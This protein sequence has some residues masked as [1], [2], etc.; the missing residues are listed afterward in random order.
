MTQRVVPFQGDSS[1]DR[2]AFL[3]SGSQGGWLGK[4][5]FFPYVVIRFRLSRPECPLALPVV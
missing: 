5:N 1:V 3:Q 4:L 2:R